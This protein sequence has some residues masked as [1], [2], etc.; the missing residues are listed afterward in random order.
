[1]RCGGGGVGGGEGGGSEAR[2][3]VE[4]GVVEGCRGFRGLGV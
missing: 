2:V 1:M 4:L 3:S